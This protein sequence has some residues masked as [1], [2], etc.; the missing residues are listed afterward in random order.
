MG[1]DALAYLK[2]YGRSRT[3][4]LLQELSEAAA[5]LPASPAPVCGMP[6]GRKQG[7]CRASSLTGSTN[8]NNTKRKKAINKNR[9]N[10][11]KWSREREIMNTTKNA[12]D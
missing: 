12:S 9:Q 1:D 2:P 10:L 7:R 3:S 11:Y 8:R 5:S 4:L 6:G